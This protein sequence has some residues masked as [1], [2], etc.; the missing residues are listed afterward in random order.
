MVFPFKTEPATFI[1]RPNRFRVVARLQST[2]VV[3][4][5]HCADPGRMRELLVPGVT[6]HVNKANN[7]NRKTAYDL[8]FVEHPIHGQLVS[9]DTRLPNQIFAEGL[10]DGFFPSFSDFQEMKAEVS[11]PDIGESGVRSRFDFR[12]VDR[13]DRPCW[14]E[15]KSVTLVEEG[16]ARFPDAPTV[17][18]QRHVRELTALTEQDQRAAVVFIVQRDDAKWVEP[19][20]AIDPKFAAA[21]IQAQDAGVELLAATCRLTTRDVVLHQMVPVF[22][23]PRPS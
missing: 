7:P 3:I 14:I 21:L 1:E 13:D 10:R 2:D 19:Y 8:R 20:V 18:G 12:L 4:D 15:V 5:A 22:A 16:V 9:L 17:R 11:A 23:Q 6:V